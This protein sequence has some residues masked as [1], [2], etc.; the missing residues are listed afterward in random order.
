[1]TS[2]AH[3]LTL[4]LLAALGMGSTALAQQ[5]GKGQSEEV[6]DEKAKE[7]VDDAE[8]AREEAE[9]AQAAAK[10]AAATKAGGATTAQGAA[11]AA[12]SA[13]VADQAS[14]QANAAANDA[15]NSANDALA[16]K[17]AVDGGT[18]QPRDAAAQAVQA[19][20]AT[21]AATAAASNA[22]ATAEAAADATA[23]AVTEPAVA[24]AAAMSTSAVVNTPLVTVR[25]VP[26]DPIRTNFAATDVNGDGSIDR[27]EARA[28]A[29]LTAQFKKFDQDGNDQL[30]I[31]EYG[32]WRDWR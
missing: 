24:P 15:V 27:T 7:A 11:Q 26:G 14:V 28:D 18:A 32:K 10:A 1:M 5:A 22:A 13:E 20:S 30:S 19:A 9:A 21:S 4:A 16:A 6:V 8:V 2:K 31:A 17:S 25:S 12:V 29:Q 3:L 23:Q